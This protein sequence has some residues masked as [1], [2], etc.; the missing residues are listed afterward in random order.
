MTWFNVATTSDLVDNSGVCVLVNGQQI[1]LFSLTITGQNQLFAIDN[2]D[3]IGQAN[4][5]A[6]GITGSIGDRLVVASP[7]YKQHFDLHNGQCIEMPEISVGVYPV[8]RQEQTIWI[9]LKSSQPRA[10]TK[11]EAMV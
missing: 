8:Q 11:M 5:L 1:A 4:V 6:R 7:L 3:P 10:E 2:F 9:Q